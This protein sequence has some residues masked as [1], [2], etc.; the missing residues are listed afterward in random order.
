MDKNIVK[1]NVIIVGV[2]KSAKVSLGHWLSQ[3]PDIFINQKDT[4]YFSIGVEG[5]QHDRVNSEEKYL[6]YF[7]EGK[8]KKVV[9]DMVTRSAVSKVAAK[10]IKEF[11]PNAKI[12][13]SIRNPAEMMFS[14]HHTLRK[15]GYETELDFYRAIK[16]EEKRK[17]RNKSGLIKNYFYREFADYYPQIKRYTDLFG[18]R[19]VKV[20]LFDDLGKRDDEQKKEKVFYDLLKFL[21]VK[22]F[23]P[24]FHREG[25]GRSMLEPKNQFYVYLLNFMHTRSRP[26]RMIIKSIIPPKL[27]RKIKDFTWKSPHIKEYLG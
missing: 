19:N 24:V 14:W 11:N 21:G 9:L 23:R 3:H 25:S 13:V 20:I 2:P 8:G 18:K 27:V 12:V 6:S 17:Q 15:I 7:K 26:M 22:K 4:D 16:L 1:P 10:K 5:T